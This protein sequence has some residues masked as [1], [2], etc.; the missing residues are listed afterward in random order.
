[1]RNNVTT[2]MLLV[3]CAAALVCHADQTGIASPCVPA[4]DVLTLT[5]DVEI[6]VPAGTTNHIEFLLGGNHTITKT[7]AGCL[8]IGIV[9][10]TG[11][12]IAVS[13]GTLAFS[14]PRTLTTTGT[15][16]HVD[17]SLTSSLVTVTENGMNFVTRWNDAEGGAYYATYDTAR[18]R[19][20][21]A[22]NHAAGLDMIDFG[23]MYYS[24][25]VGITHSDGTADPLDAATQALLKSGYGAAFNI[26]ATING[27][28]DYIYVMQD[29]EETKDLVLPTT[30]LEVPGPSVLGSARN[31]AGRGG[32]CNGYVPCLIHQRIASTVTTSY[33]LNGSWS[34][35]NP[36]GTRPAAGEIHVLYHTQNA[37][38]YFSTLGRCESYGGLRIG[39]VMMFD[40]L[41]AADERRL[42][43]AALCSKWRGMSLASLTLAQGTSLQ[44]NG[45]KLTVGTFSD[46]GAAEISGDGKLAITRKTGLNPFPVAGDSV[47]PGVMTGNP[48]HPGYAFNADGTVNV[49][50]G[51][52]KFELLSASGTFTKMGAGTLKVAAVSSGVTGIAVDAGALVVSPFEGQTPVLHFDMSDEKHMTID[53]NE[54]GTNYVTRVVDLISGG[55]SASTNTETIA[56][57]TPRIAARPFLFRNARNGH[58]LLDFGTLAA[59]ANPEGYGASMVLTTGKKNFGEIYCVFEDNEE[60]KTYAIP[61]VSYA[62]TAYLGPSAIATASGEAYYLMRGQGGNGN[63]FHLLYSNVHATYMN[64]NQCRVNNVNHAANVALPDG[65]NVVQYRMRTTDCLL[66][67]GYMGVSLPGSGIMARYARG[68]CRIGEV[69]AFAYQPHDDVR[70]AAAKALLHKWKGTANPVAYDS[71]SVAAGTSF[72]QDEADVTVGILSGAGTV[73]MS[74]TLGANGVLETTLA[75]DFSDNAL[76][77]TGTLTL[78][79]NGTLRVDADWEH[80]AAFGGKREVKVVNCANISGSV[81]GWKVVSA[82]HD[83]PVRGTVELKADGLYATLADVRGITVIFR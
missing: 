26:S 32:G 71:L 60:A 46:N 65:M 72:R 23:Q 15:L 64:S 38:V 66:S 42:L 39:E 7:G 5:G 62:T 75:N 6:A 30:K 3:N 29:R 69:M 52:S 79:A 8:E 24:G 51:T 36:R 12:S 17:A 49:T 59:T 44:V 1:M 34:S 67:L 56:V 27:V 19:P 28:K 57:G 55:L 54:D 25:N 2:I 21:L 41:L 13:E 22:A 45:H 78:P 14:D 16:F 61:E 81:D 31:Q 37:T 50:Y 18:P 82:N 68:G 70:R 76:A 9:T 40:R 74:V 58:T 47:T 73:D 33:Y 83:R 10:N 63:G 77:C 43:V 48:V 53:E 20:I 11:V 80:L 4:A 35:F